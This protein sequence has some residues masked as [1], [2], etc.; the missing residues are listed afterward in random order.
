MIKY[1]FV[2]GVIW[3]I[4]YFFIK[5]K[6]NI[7]RYDYKQKQKKKTIHSNDMVKCASC[8]IYCDIDEC[9]LNSKK[10]YCSNECATQ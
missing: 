9:I 10:H 5:K 7:D 3:A 2:I 6:P 4:Y 8:G 1:L